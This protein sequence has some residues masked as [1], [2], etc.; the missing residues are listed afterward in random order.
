MR[1]ILSGIR[2]PFE[3][4]EVQILAE[5]RRA[6]SLP[7]DVPASV[8]R[9]SFDL[10]HNTLSGVWS[11]ELTVPEGTT[12]S[13]RPD[14]RLRPEPVLPEPTGKQKLSAAPVV[15]GFG[16][17][18]LFAALVLSMRGYRPI[19]LER[20]PSL[21]ERDRAVQAFFETGALDA[22]ANIQFGEGGAGAYS[23]GKL[24]TRVGDERCELAL[25]L[26]RRHGA[27][28]DALKLA[29]PHIGTDLLKGVVSSMREEIIRLG[30]EVRFCCAMT[31]YEEKS[32]RLSAVLTEQGAVPCDTAVLAVGHS[33]R[34]S[35]EMLYGRNVAMEQKPF[36]VGLRVEHLQADI[37]ESLYGRFCGTKGL[38]PGEYVLS[39]QTGVRKCYTFCMCP[40]GR[41]VAAASEPFGVVTNGMSDHA[42]DGINANSALCVPVDAADFGSREPLA[43]VA[44]QRKLERAAFRAGGGAFRAPAQTV[45]DFLAGR[46]TASFGKIQP[47][48]ARGTAPADL[49]SL[50]PPPVSATLNQALP[51]L[52]RKLRAFSDPQAVLTGIETR[53]SSPVRILRGEDMESLSVSGLIPCGE[54]AG[55]AGGIISAAVDGLRAAERI[56]TQYRPFE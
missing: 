19:V 13:E 28:E 27:P 12:F 44:F 24:N 43:G 26:F 21:A 42:R 54:G 8:H 53:T 15:I 33:A 7:E 16:P 36:S 52:A 31:G 55:Y 50:L 56:M 22:R 37:E 39:T 23:D 4:D 48:Y 29:R 2:L 5:A 25:S 49:N 10:R 6:L 20:G 3:T 34:D 41:V 46:A 14:L 9:Q 1:Y 38:P 47:S 30:G 32:G 45:G 17:A 51:L 35:F 40:G 18:G 11:V